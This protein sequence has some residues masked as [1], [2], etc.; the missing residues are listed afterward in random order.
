[1]RKY[2][3]FIFMAVLNVIVSIYMNQQKVDPVTLI[4]ASLSL[5]YGFLLTESNLL[6]TVRI[7]VREQSLEQNKEH[8]EPP[9]RPKEKGLTEEMI[10]NALA[11][12]EK[13]KNV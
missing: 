3:L 11:R 1:M 13:G 5:S 8:P 2:L 9:A 12:T 6:D 4:I 10:F 7:P